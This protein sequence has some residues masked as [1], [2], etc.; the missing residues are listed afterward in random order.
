MWPLLRAL[1][2]YGCSWLLA[3]SK[4]HAS[5]EALVVAGALLLLLLLMSS[6]QAGLGLELV[7]W[8]FA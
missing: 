5:A 2:A 3:A 1:A 4:Q 7:A 8:F 6:L